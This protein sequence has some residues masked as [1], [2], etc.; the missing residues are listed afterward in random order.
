MCLIGMPHFQRMKRQILL[1]QSRAVRA[2]GVAAM[3]HTGQIMAAVLRD[4]MAPLIIAVVYGGSSGQSRRFQ[5]GGRMEAVC[6]LRR[7]IKRI[8]ELGDE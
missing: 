4:M 7:A 5:V 2:C 3:V 8:E 6:C 1:D